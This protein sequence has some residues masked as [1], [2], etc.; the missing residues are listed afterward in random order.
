MVKHDRSYKENG[1]IK[2][3]GWW[4]KRKV[5]NKQSSKSKMKNR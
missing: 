1:Q 5:K 2:K 3:K 4:S